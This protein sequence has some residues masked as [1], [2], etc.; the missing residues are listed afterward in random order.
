VSDLNGTNST[1]TSF[2]LQATPG[3]FWRDR[4]F[5]VQ[6]AVQSALFLVVGSLDLAGAFNTL[7]DSSDP[8]SAVI[9]SVGYTIVFVGL[10]VQRRRPELGLTTVAVGLLV[11]A[12]AL[13][14]VYV[15]A[16][17]IVGYEA[18]FI[19]GYI[20][21]RRRAW[22]GALLV[23]ALAGATLAVLAP[24]VELSWVA[25]PSREEVYGEGSSP[26]EFVGVLT[27]LLVLIVVS[28]ALCWQL[29][30]GVRRQHQQMENLAA[31]AELAAVT[32]RNRIA[33]EMHDIVAHSLPRSS[34]RPTADA[35]R[36]RRSRSWRSKLSTRSRRPVVRH[37]HRCGSSSASCARA[38]PAT[39]GPRRV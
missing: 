3:P 7:V 30:L 6:F 15:L 5:W 14:E 35:M 9:L 32:E 31:R 10:L 36:G 1:T 8:V 27:I 28:V 13:S 38:R 39:P 11:A 24:Y 20:R 17:G 34:P 12:V 22:L 23:G 19:S 21:R 4:G 26:R 2:A 18:W 37:W 29:G 25:G 16:A 33:R